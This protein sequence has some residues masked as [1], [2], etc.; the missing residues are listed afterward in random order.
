MMEKGKTQAITE[1]IKK[2]IS[3][4]VIGQEELTDLALAAFLSGGHVLLEGVPGL[5]KTLWARAFAKTLDINFKRTQFTADLMPADILGT[6]VFNVKDSSFELKKGPLFTQLFL[7]DEI[8][9]TPP[10]TQSA[11][12]EVM[13]E[14]SITIDGEMEKLEEPF[15]VVATQ[16]PV[17]YEGTYPLPEA[18]VDRFMMKLLLTYP[19]IAAEK[20]M[21][22][23]YDS[24]FDSSRLEDTHIEKVCDS[25]R[26][27]E[28]RA[29]IKDVRV[30]DSIL[31]Y[32]ISIIEFT[33]RIH[34]VQFGSSPRGSIALFLSAKAYAAMQG[35]D[36]VVPDDVKT[37]ALPILR[38]RIILRPEAEMDG[39]TTDKV[40][41]N[42]LSQIKVPR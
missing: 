34:I 39:A 32:I 27:L 20:E 7:A 30:D 33:R 22:Q 40:V 2:Q 18:L 36:F 25:G 5:A 16:N 37:L 10:K 11:L 14:R 29:E 24:G 42:L 41:E 15:M 19:G 26:F 12:L 35:R 9:R 23:M 4:V 38:H 8:N 21:L 13:E 28:C 17:E 3:R 6:T 31:N 1:M